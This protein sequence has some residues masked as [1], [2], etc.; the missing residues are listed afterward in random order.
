MSIGMLLKLL[1]SSVRR[2]L[3]KRCN[4]GQDAAQ[5]FVLFFDVG[6]RFVQ[7]L[8]DVRAFGQVQEMTSSV[9]SLADTPR[10][11]LDNLRG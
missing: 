3:S 8:A 2:G 1:S 10:S 9:P 11:T 6:H 4:F 5:V 7:R